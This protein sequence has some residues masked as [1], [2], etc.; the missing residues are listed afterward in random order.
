[1]FLAKHPCW[2]WRDLQDTPARVIDA[3]RLIEQEA[4]RG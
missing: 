3:L 1:M 2:T 4:G